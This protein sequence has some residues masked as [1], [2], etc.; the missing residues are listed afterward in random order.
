MRLR[1]KLFRELSADARVVSHDVRM[2]AWQSDTVV[3]V[4]S[5]YVYR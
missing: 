1:P 4:D 5:S 2:G 3:Q